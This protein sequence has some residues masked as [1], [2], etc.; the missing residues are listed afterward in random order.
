MQDA[1]QDR[2]ND[3]A[4]DKDV[5]ECWARNNHARSLDTRAGVGVVPGTGAWPPNHLPLRLSIPDS[6]IGLGSPEYHTGTPI[7]MTFTWTSMTA[8]Y[9]ATTLYGGVTIESTIGKPYE[10][11]YALEKFTGLNCGIVNTVSGG[12]C[13]LKYLD[14]IVAKHSSYRHEGT[15]SMHLAMKWDFRENMAAG[16]RAFVATFIDQLS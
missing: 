8:D 7:A 12:I 3:E 10:H 1:E 5:K 11:K 15:T 6:I 9:A 2:I 16:P 4:L 13:A 14:Q